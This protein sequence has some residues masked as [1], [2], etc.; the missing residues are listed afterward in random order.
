M[1]KVIVALSFALQRSLGNSQSEKDS[2]SVY[3]VLIKRAFDILCSLIGMIVLSPLYLIIYIA[4]KSEDGECAI[5]RQERIGYNG[6]P[7]TLYKFRSMCIDAEADDRPILCSEKDHRL[8]KVGCF[9]RSHH[10]DE[11][12]QLWNV[13]KGEM[14]FVGYRPERKYFIDKILA[15][16]PCYEKLYTMR[17]GLFSMATLYNGYT[18][19]LEKM[20]TRLEMDLDYLENC[21]FWIDLK[22]IFLTGF[23]ILTGKK[24]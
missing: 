14:S 24:F 10:L 13:L 20:L 8:T 22:I 7:F 23:S 17:P 3:G 18:D 9:L 19:T 4:I 6:N 12:P 16:N 2:V 21:S 15:H 5:F 1:E 11:L